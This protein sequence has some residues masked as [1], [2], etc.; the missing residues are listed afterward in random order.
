MIQIPHLYLLQC[1]LMGEA[2]ETVLV[3]SMVLDV[4]SGVVYDSVEVLY[5]NIFLYH[6]VLYD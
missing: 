6:G 5:N 2:Y 4:Y 3:F 1:S